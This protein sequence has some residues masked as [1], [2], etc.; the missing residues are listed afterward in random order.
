MGQLADFI[1]SL[2][3]GR[4]LPGELLPLASPGL[5][6]LL[7]LPSHSFLLLLLVLLLLQPSIGV[8]GDSL[9]TSVPRILFLRLI[10]LQ[11]AFEAYIPSPIAT[12]S[13]LLVEVIQSILSVPIR[14]GAE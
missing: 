1:S 9:P 6:L 4:L 12:S 5:S 7:L 2:S 10:T 13:L 8:P 3:R 14:D 11:S